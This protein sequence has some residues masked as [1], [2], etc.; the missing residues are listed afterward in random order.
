MK[1]HPDLEGSL[2]G[3]GEHP[4]PPAGHPVDVGRA[5]GTA[6][7]VEGDVVDIERSL[8]IL[9]GAVG[10][11]HTDSG[12]PDPL[13]VAINMRSESLVYSELSSILTRPDPSTTD[14]ESSGL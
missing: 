3:G 6:V 8:L 2:S 13:Q 10:C 12:R 4:Y 9:A 14:H 7:G 1:A 5:S 11:A